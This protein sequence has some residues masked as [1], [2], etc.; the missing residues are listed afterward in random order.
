[1]TQTAQANIP[2]PPVAVVTGVARG[3][4]LA[5][6][7]RFC[8]AGSVVILV[9]SDASLVRE[10]ASRL[11][12][13]AVAPDVVHRW[14][15]IDV[16]VNNAGIAGAAAPTTAYPLAEWRRVMAINIDAVFY[17]IKAVLPHMLVRKGGRIINIA[18]IAGNFSGTVL[19]QVAN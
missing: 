10:V 13:G 9:D 12:E 16:L 1:M 14:S 18:F 3:I 6:A 4:G 2:A 8:R 15:R 19:H 11:G 7:A 17:C 5:I